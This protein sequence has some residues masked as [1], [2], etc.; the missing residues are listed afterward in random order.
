MV[1]LLLYLRMQPMFG[2]IGNGPSI[3]VLLFN[4][5]TFIT[6]TK[7]CAS[8]KIFL[9]LIPHFQQIH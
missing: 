7:I 6:P 3:T 1:L 5:G 2:Q 9:I 8:C 4:F